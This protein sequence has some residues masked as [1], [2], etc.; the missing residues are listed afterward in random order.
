M[1]MNTIPVPKNLRN[2]KDLVVVPRSHYERLL[3]TSNRCEEEDREWREFSMKNFLR[4]Y[5]PSDSIY[6]SL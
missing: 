2:E 1:Q 4:S 3:E 5:G 6:D